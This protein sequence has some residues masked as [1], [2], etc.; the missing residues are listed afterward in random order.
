MTT[1]LADVGGTNVRFALADATSPSPLL[2]DTIRR[3]RV[4]D[5]ASFTDAARQYLVDAGAR[6][7]HAVFAFAGPVAGDEVQIT[8]HPWTVVLPRVR[9][10]LGLQGLRA[11]NDFAAMSLAVGLLGIDDV[12]NIGA[13]T[14]IRVGAA[15][16]QT[17]ATVGPGTGLGVGALIVR[18]GHIHTLDTEGGHLSFAPRDDLEIEVLRRLAKRF[19]RVSNERVIC[20]AGL[21]NLYSVLAEIDGVNADTL[22]PKDITQRAT[23]DSDVRC[24]R[25]VELFCALLGAVAGDLVLGFGAWDGVYLTGGLT[26]RL[27]PWLQGGEFRRRFEDKGRFG[28]RLAG[29]PTLAVLHNDAGLL[30][31]AARAVLDAGGSLINRPM[32]DQAA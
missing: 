4:A 26:P 19:G 24:T 30:G 7:T 2:A 1:L 3:Y 29:V 25:A 14:P 17:F 31:A 16:Q 15:A 5:F 20:G 21:V 11:L 6:P 28:T 18:E 13:A 23:D 10:E 22:E 27:R 12:E 9:S 32:P 8:N